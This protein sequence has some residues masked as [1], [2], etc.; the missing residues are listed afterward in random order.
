[1]QGRLWFIW[2]ISLLL[3]P[4]LLWRSPEEISSTA[5]WTSLH[6]SLQNAAWQQWRQ[7]SSCPCKKGFAVRNICYPCSRCC[8][9]LFLFFFIQMELYQLPAPAQELFKENSKKPHILRNL[10]ISS[11]NIMLLDALVPMK[12]LDQT[13]WNYSD[14]F[15]L[16]NKNIVGKVGRTSLCRKLKTAVFRPASQ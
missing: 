5:P 12:Q 15:R 10:P 9:T 8:V 16:K 2:S 4:W 13:Q 6:T 3:T 1:M 11:S 14:M 7:V